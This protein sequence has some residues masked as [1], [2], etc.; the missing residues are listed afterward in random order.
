MG[1]NTNTVN[2]TTTY[3]QALGDSGKE[4]LPFKEKKNRAEPG[5]GRGCHLPSATTDWGIER[6]NKRKNKKK[7]VRKEKPKRKR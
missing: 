3:E 5:T 2:Q 1:E 6:K 4:K 7:K